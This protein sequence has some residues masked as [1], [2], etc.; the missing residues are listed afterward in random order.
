VGGWVWSDFG[1][2][3]MVRTRPMNYCGSKIMLH[4][5]L[6]YWSGRVRPDFFPGGSDRVGR[7]D[8]R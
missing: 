7:V 2:K 5:H 1:S 8:G 6:L 4:T 3:I